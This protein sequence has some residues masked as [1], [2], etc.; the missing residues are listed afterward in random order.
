MKTTFDFGD[1]ESSFYD[2]P[3]NPPSFEIALKFFTHSIYKNHDETE[4]KDLDTRDTKVL[5]FKNMD[6]ENGEIQSQIPTEVYI[7]I[8]SG[9]LHRNHKIWFCDYSFVDYLDCQINLKLRLQGIDYLSMDDIELE[10][11]ERI[12]LYSVS[13]DFLR[14]M[15]YDY[16]NSAMMTSDEDLELFIAQTFGK[17][18]TGFKIPQPPESLEFNAA[19][20]AEIKTESKKISEML[21]A[22]YEQ[23]SPAIATQA[24]MQQSPAS[25][26]LNLNDALLEIVKILATKNEWVRDELQAVLKQGMK[27]EGVLEHINDAFFDY[28]DEAF[29]EGDDPIEINVKL[30]K[31][32]FK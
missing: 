15:K 26:A 20:I 23:D 19:N 8:L 16:G 13:V 5:T 24:N 27:F 31:E 32:I 18:Q 10:E 25:S 28:C 11:Y 2:V 22:I 9:Y 30:Y 3:I 4:S 1:T 14:N 6:F 17:T 21:N 29:I 12:A 7:D